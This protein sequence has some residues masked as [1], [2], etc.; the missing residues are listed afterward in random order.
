MWASSPA[1]LFRRWSSSRYSIGCPEASR[2]HQ[3][4]FKP[5]PMTPSLNTSSSLSRTYTSQD[6]KL[7]IT[8]GF[9]SAE[10]HLI[11]CHPWFS[12]RA[13]FPPT[14]NLFG[15]ASGSLRRVFWNPFWPKSRDVSST[16]SSCRPFSFVDT[17]LPPPTAIPTC[18]IGVRLFPG[19]GTN[20]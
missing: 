16:E 2:R 8:F 4:V 10:N 11:Y 9:S 15:A 3:V 12:H 17:S 7:I 5:L 18:F 19:R 13:W 1:N 14:E 6:N 20:L